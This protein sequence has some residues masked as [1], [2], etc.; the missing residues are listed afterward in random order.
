MSM[1]SVYTL[2]DSKKW[3]EIIRSF[4]EHDVYYLSG[5]VKAFELHGDGTPLMFA[6]EGPGIRGVNVVMKRDVAKDPRFIGKI[7]EGEYWDFA[8]PYGYGGWLIDGDENTNELFEKYEVWCKKHRIASEFVRFHPE[9]ENWNKVVDR[10]EVVPLGNTV[11]IDL[12]GRDEILGNMSGTC[13]NRIR[14][15]EKAGVKIYNGRNP[16]LLRQFKN[17]Y[18]ITMQRDCASRYYYFPEEFYESVLDDL[19]SN[20]EIFY[21]QMPDGAIAASAIMIFADGKMNY[22][23]GGTVQE[24]QQYAPM[25]MLFYKAALWG[26]TNGYKT[27]HLGGGRG[28]KNDSLLH[29][30]KGFYK[31][32]LKQFC[33]GKKIFLKEN[34]DRLLELR[35]G[36]KD[37]NY[38]PLYRG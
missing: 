32:E 29:F 17:I 28:S 25:N 24:Y 10:Y 37:A 21:A 38:F 35:D 27:M 18:E 16:E 13:R 2:E 12:R 22:H 11:S 34:Y 3:D 8:T 5:Y 30:K 33:V 26:N 36:I 23:L 19:P 6:Y 31:N 1:L 7:S 9:L 20:A 14:K 15:A 4:P